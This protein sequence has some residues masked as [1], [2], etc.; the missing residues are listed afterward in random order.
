[1]TE[2]KVEIKKYKVEYWCDKCGEGLVRPT[3]AVIDTNP[4][5]YPHR[6]SKCGEDYCF[7]KTY[8]YEKDEE[9]GE[10]TDGSN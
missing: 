9:I 4:P 2:V 8:P 3:G 10:W 5:I 1:M 6:C 7:A